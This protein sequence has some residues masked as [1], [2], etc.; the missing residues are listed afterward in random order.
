ME[1][2]SVPAVCLFGA[3]WP[4]MNLRQ[5]G[6]QYWYHNSLCLWWILNYHECVFFKKRRRHK[7]QSFKTFH[8][9][10]KKMFTL[11]SISSL[12]LHPSLCFCS[13]RLDVVVFNIFIAK[14][15]WWRR[16][17]LLY[18]LAIT[19]L[20][21][22][23]KHDRLLLLIFSFFFVKTHGKIVRRFY[24]VSRTTKTNLNNSN[25]LSNLGNSLSNRLFQ[26]LL[27]RDKFFLLVLSTIRYI[28]N[29][30]IV[31]YRLKVRFSRYD[32]NFARAR[33]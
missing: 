9:S 16:W 25:L 17:G 5:N 26:R 12:Q 23:H 19:S 1:M 3:C 7:L 31:D 15:E 2:K 24:N 21:S 13:T 30:T 29:R 27:C 22:I 20:L 33:F 4:V 10:G 14:L 32:S 18:C 6:Y 11:R 28:L 8:C